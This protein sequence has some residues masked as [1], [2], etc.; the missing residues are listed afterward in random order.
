M[1]SYKFI[2]MQQELSGDEFQI[3][4]R[5]VGSIPCDCLITTLLNW[6]GKLFVGHANRKIMVC[7][8]LF[9]FF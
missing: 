2:Y 8:L 1:N 5:P 3:E 6:Q 4:S 7:S 9:T